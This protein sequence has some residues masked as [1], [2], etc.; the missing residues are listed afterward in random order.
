MLIYLIT[1]SVDGYITDREGSFG[2][3]VPDEELFAFHLERVR[4]LGGVLCGR[5]LYETMLPWETD[6]GTRQDGPSTEFAE[7]WTALPKVVFSRTLDRVEGRA[8]L[9]QGS[10]AEEIAAMSASTP[11]DV[12]IGGADLAG[13]AIERGLVDE[14][15]IFRAPRILGGGTSLLPAVAQAVPLELVES[16]EFST[17]V[18]YERYRR[19]RH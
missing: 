7:V 11:K 4:E 16:R 6:A 10:V 2:W 3:T 8:C 13:Q 19:L 5:R 1:A 9:A 14:I 18:L 12:E 17:P 15:R